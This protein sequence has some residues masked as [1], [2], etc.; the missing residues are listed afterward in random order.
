MVLDLPKQHEDVEVCI[1]HPGLITS[2]TTWGRAAFASVINVTKAIT[3][4]SWSDKVV[5]L[6]QVAAAVLEQ[7][8]HGW[9][10][11][12]LSNKDLVRIGTAALKSK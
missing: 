4:N 9:D 11:Q 5:D 1:P 7:A 12:M 6:S 10:E 2:S 3:F 8:V